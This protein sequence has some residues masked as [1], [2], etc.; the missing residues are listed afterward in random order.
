[1][2]IQMLNWFA[3]L[4][5]YVPFRNTSFHVFP[6]ESVV[7]TITALSRSKDRIYRDM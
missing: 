4:S 3:L 6:K 2:Y 1:M 5:L 7:L